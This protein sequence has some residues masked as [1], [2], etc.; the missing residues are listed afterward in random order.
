MAL[1]HC[2]G[3]CNSCISLPLVSKSPL[4]DRPLGGNVGAN[5]WPQRAD[6]ECDHRRTTRP[7]AVDCFSTLAGVI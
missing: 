1:A 6:D 5:A 3:F 7:H 4:P 2:P